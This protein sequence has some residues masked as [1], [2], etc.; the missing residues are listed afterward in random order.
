[1]LI[2]KRPA[3]AA[4]LYKNMRNGKEKKI[5]LVKQILRDHYRDLYPAGIVYLAVV[6]FLACRSG[7]RKETQGKSQSPVNK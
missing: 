2:W 6:P 4:I 5:S 3:V 1:M 7:K